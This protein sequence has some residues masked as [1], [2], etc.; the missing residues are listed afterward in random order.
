M[1]SH[2]ILHNA[3]QESNYTWALEL[4]DFELSCSPSYP[5]EREDYQRHAI[6]LFSREVT[7][8]YCIINYIA[9]VLKEHID[10][11]KVDRL[12][13]EYGF[14]IMRYKIR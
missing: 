2:N 7:Q 9:G 14:D 13:T 5:Y 12:F 3:I 4:L 11:K 6:D 8:T 10:F 1:H